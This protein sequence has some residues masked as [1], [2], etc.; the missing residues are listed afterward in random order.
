[1]IQILFKR[2]VDRFGFGSSGLGKLQRQ[3]FCPFLDKRSGF[4]AA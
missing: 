2:L 1:M 3:F 4:G